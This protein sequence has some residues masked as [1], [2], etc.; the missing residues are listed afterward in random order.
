MEN[1]KHHKIVGTYNKHISFFGSFF[2]YLKILKN[3]LYTVYY[4]NLTI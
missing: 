2:F 4:L 3:E 1:E